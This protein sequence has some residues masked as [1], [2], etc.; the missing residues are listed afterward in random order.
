MSKIDKNGLSSYQ[1]KVIE[2]CKSVYQN[3]LFI[4]NHMDNEKYQ[5]YLI[6]ANIIDKIKEKINYEKLEPKIANY[7]GGTINYNE[8]KKYI[9][10]ITDEDFISHVKSIMVEETRKDIDL[11]EQF[12][13]NWDEISKNRFKFN[14]KEEN[15]KWLKKCNK[16]GFIKFYEKS[17]L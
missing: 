10:D 1:L 5:G 17:F 6:E 2:I 11:E 4:N 12:D 16:E 8:I 13:R 7:F 9:K 3:E 14:R 15:A